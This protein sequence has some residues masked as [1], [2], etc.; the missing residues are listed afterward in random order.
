MHL[1]EE[2]L[3]WFRGCPQR[4][5]RRF[6]F[7]LRGGGEGG[8]SGAKEE[9]LRVPLVRSAS[10]LRK[11]GCPLNRVSTVLVWLMHCILVAPMNSL[12]FSQLVSS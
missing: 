11:L 4:R 12:V 7:F 5:R 1:L 8:G 9:I 3:P 10:L 6:F 2:P